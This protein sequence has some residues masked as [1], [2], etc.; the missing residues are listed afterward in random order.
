LIYFATLDELRARKGWIRLSAR[1]TTVVELHKGGLDFERIAKQ[2]GVTL[3]TV[4][5]Y[6]RHVR[7]KLQ[8]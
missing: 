4:R 6:W 3:N 7:E 1:E 5:I 8:I 2:L